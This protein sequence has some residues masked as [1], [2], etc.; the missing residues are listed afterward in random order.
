MGVAVIIQVLYRFLE[1]IL[2]RF[3]HR[4]PVEVP[5]DGALRRAR[6]PG[7][8]V[9]G[10]AHGGLLSVLGGTSAFAFGSRQARPTFLL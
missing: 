3:L 4:L 1:R 7:D 5:G 2:R 8:V 10:R 6:E 9:N